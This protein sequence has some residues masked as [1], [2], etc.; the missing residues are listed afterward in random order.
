MPLRKKS[1]DTLTPKQ[2]KTVDKNYTRYMKSRKGKQTPDM[3]IE[4]YLPI[5]QK[6]ALTYL[7]MAAI[8]LPI[9]IIVLMVLYPQMA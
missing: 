3:T 1:F 7:I 9:Y 6:Q 4:E 5:I 8:V 2:L